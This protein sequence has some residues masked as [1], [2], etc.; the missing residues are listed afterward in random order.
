MKYLAALLTV[1]LL[2]API[3]AQPGNLKPAVAAPL[4]IKFPDRIL[5]AIDDMGVAAK[6]MKA[7]V[8][9]LE[10]GAVQAAWWDGARTGGF[11]VGLLCVL[12]YLG[13]DRW[14]SKAP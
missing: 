10:G 3:A 14:R 7:T 4:D 11:A 12:L 1:A 5:I 13:V 8:V 9:A 2:L 6:Q